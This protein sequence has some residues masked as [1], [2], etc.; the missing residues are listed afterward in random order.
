[1]PVTRLAVLLGDPVA[2]SLSP[3]IHNTAFRELGIGAVYRA[4]R[5]PAA[6]LPSAVQ[7]LRRPNVLGANLTIPHKE[8]TLALLDVLDATARAVGAVNTVVSEQDGRVLTGYNTDV[9]GFLEPLQEVTLE[10]AAVVLGSGGAARAVAYALLVA[11]SLD[12]IWIAARRKERADAVVRDLSLLDAAGVLRS[13]GL[14]QAAAV[15]REA[16]LVVNATPVGMAATAAEV[17]IEP[18]LLR[19]GQVVYDLIYNPRRTALLRHASAAGAL[20]IGGL[21]MLVGQAAAAFRLWTGRE[22]PRQVV[23]RVLRTADADPAQG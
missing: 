20:P 8:A 9:T 11:F 23:H 16:A 15:I 10:G 17:P 18:H 14:A 4:L 5:T 6:A 2:H 13:T 7:G 3:L 21:D 1:M 12:R 22:M 19:G